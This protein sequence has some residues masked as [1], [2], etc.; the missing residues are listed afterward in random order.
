MNIELGKMQDISIH[1]VKDM[2]F[3]RVSTST[4]DYVKDKYFTTISIK[5]HDNQTI[6]ITLW[7]DDKNVLHQITK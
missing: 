5:T 7:A 3:D 4:S 1:D 2:S 6:D